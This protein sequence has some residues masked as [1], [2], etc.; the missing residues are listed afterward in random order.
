MFKPSLTTISPSKTLT[1]KVTTKKLQQLIFLNDNTLQFICPTD[2][3]FIL[4]RKNVLTTIT[5]NQQEHLGI[6]LSYKNTDFAHWQ[7]SDNG[8]ALILL[9]N[10][11]RAVIINLTQMKQYRELLTHNDT[12]SFSDSMENVRGNRNTFK[13]RCV[14]SNDGSHYIIRN[15][16][17]PNTI[18]YSSIHAIGLNGI[19]Y[20]INSLK[21]KL[22]KN[23]QPSTQFVLK[24]F[25]Q[26][27]ILITGMNDGSL[28]I[29]P[30]TKDGTTRQ[31][32]L[33]DSEIIE[34]HSQSND[35]Y[36]LSRESLKIM[37]NES[38]LSS[39]S[40]SFKAIHFLLQLPNTSQNLTIQPS[41]KI[42]PM[43]LTLI[44]PTSKNCFNLEFF[45]FNSGLKYIDIDNPVPIIPP[46]LVQAEQNKQE[47]SSLDSAQTQQTCWLSNSTF[48]LYT[49]TAKTVSCYQLT[50]R[51]PSTNE[52]KEQPQKETPS[53]IPTHFRDV[54][55]KLPN[56]VISDQ[57]ILADDQ[58]HTTEYGN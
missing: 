11:Y 41:V 2:N 52:Q 23:M 37:P 9:V 13:A 56:P 20:F 58:E 21:I 12:G 51:S 49:Y 1:S 43:G 39:E 34:I 45:D 10:S 7:R 26:P 17:I 14:P 54:F 42:T 22:S 55:F 31:K 33:F 25:N 24:Q 50:P 5:H 44:Y 53:I 27:P 16:V 38:L 29:Q 30:L 8:D 3:G 19:P 18:G 36:V 28:I 46:L 32:K 15:I 40:L 35:L 47:L 4:L 48:L 6:S 57:A